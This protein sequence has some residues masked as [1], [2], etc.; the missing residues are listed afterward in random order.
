MGYLAL[1][2][3]STASSCTAIGS[4]ALKG[5]TTGAGNTAVGYVAMEACTTGAYNCPLYTSDAADQ[6]HRLTLA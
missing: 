2:S 1:G 4:Q 3:T 6:Q 5:N